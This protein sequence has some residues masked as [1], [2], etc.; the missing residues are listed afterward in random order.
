MIT[1]YS[2]TCHLLDLAPYNSLIEL[3]ANRRS[4]HAKTEKRWLTN[5][6]EYH[7]VTNRGEF[8]P[9]SHFLAGTLV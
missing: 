2:R 5:W 7:S 6:H 4:W 1:V 8:G 3:S 9:V